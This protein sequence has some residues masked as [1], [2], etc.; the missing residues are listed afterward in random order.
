MRTYKLFGYA[1]KNAPRGFFA[2]FVAAANRMTGEVKAKAQD[3]R[4]W[5]ILELT[6]ISLPGFKI[7]KAE[8]N[9]TDEPGEAENS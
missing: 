4:P 7:I 3:K 8:E 9:G 6:E 1:P 2:G 5:F